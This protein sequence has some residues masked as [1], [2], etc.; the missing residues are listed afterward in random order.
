MPNRIDRHARLLAAIVFCFSLLAVGAVAQ[1]SM[2]EITVSFEVPRLVSK[3]IFVRYDGTVVYLPVTAV[4]SLLDINISLDQSRTRLEGFFASKDQRYELRPL[5]EKATVNGTTF[6]LAQ[7]EFQFNGVEMYLRLD[8]FKRLF[9]L[10]MTFDFSQLR[11]LLPLNDQFPA[12]KRLQRKQMR[13]KLRKTEE[14]LKN[15]KVIPHK[16]ELFS[17]G[18]ADW[19][20]STNPVGGGGHYADVVIGSMLLAGDL[21]LS[22]TGNSATG[23][24]ADQLNY[25]WRYAFDTNPYIS[26]AEL[27]SVNP[28][29]ILSRS[30]D[31]AL[32][33]NRPLTQRS[34]FQ[35]INI[36][37]AL[38]PGWE[39]EL[40]ADGK[41]IDFVEADQGGEYNFSVDVNYGS[42]DLQL[43]MFGPN[44]EIRTEN[45][46]VRVPY[47]LIPRRQFE[48]T[49]AGGRDAVINN[50]RW[51]SQGVGYYG[52]THWLSAGVG[53]DIPLTPSSG[54]GSEEA[55][56]FSGEATAQIAG[57][58]IANTSIAPNHKTLIS[59]NYSMPSA[60]SADLSVTQF[61][62]NLFRN[63]VEQ[64]SNLALSLSAPIHLGSRYFGLRYYVARDS[65]ATFRSTTVN[66]GLTGSFWRIYCNYLGRY[67]TTEFPTRTTRALSSQTLVST[68]LVRWLR[69]QFRID[70]DHTLNTLSRFGVYITRRVFKTG[71]VSLS[72]E[73]SPQNRTNSILL[74]IN[75]FTGAANFSTRA[76]YSDQKLSMSQIQRGSIR[77]DR[78]AGA[79]RFDRRNG[80]GY[81]SAVVRPFVDINNDGMIGKNEEILKGVK[82]RISGVGGRP[83]GRGRM[84]YYDGLRPYDSYTIQVD[85]TS[86][87]NPMLRPAY[88]NYKVSVNPNV[89]TTID[90][91]VVMAADISGLVERQTQ[92]GKVGV[93]GITLHV[94]NLTKDIVTEIT[95]F[96]SGQYYYLGLI[97]GKY[98]AYLDPAQMERYGYVSEPA[99]LEFEILPST[100][101]TSV[102]NINFTLLPKP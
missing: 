30:L 46:H 33:T 24:E 83:I 31:G 21:T 49:V 44:G 13:D 75:F 26:Q 86:I 8:Q 34:Y 53:A 101:G 54:K 95:T 82:A 60:I 100:D 7:A 80:A 87:D 22:G 96:S 93:G 76:Q 72:Y 64:K 1:G 29:G 90:V 45:R 71:Q 14:A 65:Y 84:F 12:Y 25:H 37:G 16:R 52:I 42:S 89:V 36:T 79:V 69:P 47:T 27:G 32:L 6:T 102:E 63:P 23:I 28:G 11:I 59:L 3:D 73:H 62:K 56:L 70:Y 97:P 92:A 74:G 15:L 98:R 81:G 39:V 35:T 94:I 9:G 99:S 19:T 78:A 77:Y 67:K 55:K 18:V 4:F 2:E 68:D 43:K 88:E 61:Q 85:P 17:G 5:E 57:S 41:L 10:E 66:Y 38:E 40:Y 50:N 91:P 51:Y 58:L 20:L 48:Y